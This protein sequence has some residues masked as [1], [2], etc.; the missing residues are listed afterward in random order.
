MLVLLMLHARPLNQH[1][2]DEGDGLDLEGGF[3]GV[4]GVMT[5][6]NHRPRPRADL[7]LADVETLRSL[8]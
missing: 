6:W 7:S 1:P 2:S 8:S 4:F 3:E 5:R